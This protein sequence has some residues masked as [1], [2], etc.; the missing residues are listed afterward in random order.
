MEQRVAVIL[1]SPDKNREVAIPMGRLSGG[2]V[3]YQPQSLARKPGY[4]NSLWK[5]VQKSTFNK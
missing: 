3:P 4:F 5:H 2:L 1:P